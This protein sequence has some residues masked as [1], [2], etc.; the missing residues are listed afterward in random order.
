MTWNEAIFVRKVGHYISKLHVCL[1]FESKGAM[2]GLKFLS[3]GKSK[4]R[5]CIGW[6]I[7]LRMMMLKEK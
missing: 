1:S 7:S 4:L 6:P 3:K 5:S 2:S